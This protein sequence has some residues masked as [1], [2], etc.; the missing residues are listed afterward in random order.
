LIHSDWGVQ[1]IYLNPE[2]ASALGDD[3]FWTWFK[4]EFPSSRYG[5][6]KRLSSIDVVIQYSTLGF[7]MTGRSIASLMELYPE[8]RETFGSDQWDDRIKKV[9]EAA[10]FCTYRVVPSPANVKW[11]E[12]FGQ[13]D[14]I[15]IGVNVDMFRPMYRKVELRAKYG[16]PHR[17][18]VGIWGGTTHMMKGYDLFL[19][20]AK[21]HP[22]VF[23]I[24]IWKWEHES[25]QLPRGIHSYTGIKQQQISELFNCADFFLSTGRLKSFFMLEWEAMACD[26]PFISLTER[27]FYPAFHPRNDVMDRGWDRPS[28]KQQWIKYLDERG[29]QW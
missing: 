15:P 3:T 2:N 6:P 24:V 23:W 5:L 1:M 27:E 8:M 11:Y 16:I 4:R 10:K 12:Q 22:E 14:V 13:V 17:M 21:E 29:V 28:V 9:Y 18:K 25:E 7:P 19:Q 26:L 20:Y